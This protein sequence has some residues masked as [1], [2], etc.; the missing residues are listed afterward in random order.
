VQEGE[1]TR[2]GADTWARQHN[3]ARFDFKPIQTESNVF[4]T[5][6][7]LPQTLT[8]PKVPFRAPKIENKTWLERS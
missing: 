6:S 5:D 2:R 4:Q 3:A 1:V 8:D 7:N